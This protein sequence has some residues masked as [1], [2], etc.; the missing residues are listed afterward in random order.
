MRRAT[1][2]KE[3]LMQNSWQEL[4][5]ENRGEPTSSG[6]AFE[7]GFNAAFNI[8]SLTDFH[9]DI[10][11]YAF[12]YALGRMSYS[13]S[14]MQ[15]AIKDLWLEISES[16]RRIIKRDIKEYKEQYGKIGMDCDEVGWMD[17]LELED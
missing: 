8:F 17:L 12:R 1:V 10:L 14:I 5:Q 16:D 11:I 4:C 3:Q 7:E 6:E 15:D 9:R 2:N 13:T